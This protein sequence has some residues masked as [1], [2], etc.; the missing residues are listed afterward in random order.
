LEAVHLGRDAGLGLG[1]AQ[2]LLLFLLAARFFLTLP[3]LGL[4]ALL[5]ELGLGLSLVED[6]RPQVAGIVV[7]GPFDCCFLVVAHSALLVVEAGGRWGEVRR[8]AVIMGRSVAIRNRRSA[9]GVWSTSMIAGARSERA[10][11]PAGR[12]GDGTRRR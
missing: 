5:L 8:P 10:Q 2:A 3:Y 9:E 1:P 4:D 11:R 6:A 7:A 12:R